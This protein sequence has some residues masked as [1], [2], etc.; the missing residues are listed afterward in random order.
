MSISP[1]IIYTRPARLPVLGAGLAAGLMGGLAEVA[2][3]ALYQQAAGASA[4]HV[5][6][7]VTESFSPALAAGPYAAPLG[8]AIH[9]TIA[10]ALGLALVAVLRRLLPGLAGT[11][12]EAAVTVAA[13]VAIWA[14]NFFVVLPV[15]NPAFV[16]VVPLGVSLVSKA[17]FGVAAALVLV[18]ADRTSRR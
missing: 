6:R 15:V 11:K 2:W 14:F 16:S 8:I 12:A 5:A 18:R 13:L 1:D 9:M 7:G 3:I 4:A 10:V 17:L